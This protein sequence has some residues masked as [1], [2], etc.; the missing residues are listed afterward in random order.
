MRTPS[1]RGVVQLKA[2]FT[3]I[4]IVV[5][6]LSYCRGWPQTYVILLLQPPKFCVTDVCCHALFGAFFSFLNDVWPGFVALTGNTRTLE[7]EARG[8]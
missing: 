6:C 2:C 7:A 3:V 1:I 8:S 4:V 5:V